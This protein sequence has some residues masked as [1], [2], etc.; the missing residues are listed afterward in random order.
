MTDTEQQAAKTKPPKGGRKGGALFPKINLQQALD[1][2]RKL[3]AKTHTG[4]QPEKTILPGVFGNA[5]PMGKV[6]ASAL[7]QYNLLEGPIAAYKATQLAKDIGAALEED[8]P[9]LLERAFL[10]AKVFKEV[11]DT[12][13]GDTVSKA[14]IEQRAK[15][16]EVH[17]TSA[18][19]CAQL[20]IES[21]VTAKMGTLYG[22]SLALVKAGETAPAGDAAPDV[23]HET[24]LDEQ[25]DEAA[26]RAAPTTP[27][28][29]ANISKGKQPEPEKVAPPHLEKPVVTL[30]LTV[31]ATSDPDKLEKQLKLLRQYGVI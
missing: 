2:A 10:N 11:F 16:L 15:G 24:E 31:D 5:G 25:E 13:H 4:A 1:Y 9:P 7:K 18:E 22:D 19:E 3:V 12:F 6:R 17:P 30:S 14:R 27:P 26:A 28:N 21:A 8:L 29:P 20:F 23:E